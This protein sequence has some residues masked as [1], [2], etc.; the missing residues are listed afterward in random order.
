MS[1]SCSYLVLPAEEGSVWAE[2]NNW[3]KQ[4]TNYNL[5]MNKWN[6]K[7]IAQQNIRWHDLESD[8]V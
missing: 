1:A 3:L 8:I 4:E 6:I 2:Q 7:A 5:M